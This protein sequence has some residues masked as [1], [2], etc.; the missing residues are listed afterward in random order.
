M[1]PS[2]ISR[3][4]ATRAISRRI[5]LWHEI[6][7]ASGV[8]SMMISTPVAASIARI[9]RPSRPMMRPFISSLGQRQHR[10][11]ALGDEL[12]RQP[13]DRDR[14]DPLGATVGLLARLLLDHPDMLGGLVPRLPDHLLDQRALGFLAGQPGDR[15]EPAA[16]FVNQRLMLG[17]L[18]G[19]RLL[20]I[21]HGL[22]APIEIGLAPLERLD[23]FLE[24]SP[25]APAAWSPRRSARAGARA[26]HVR[27]RR[28]R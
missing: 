26:A 24:A 23:P 8:S 7:T 13:L 22:V 17:F 20:A 1:R 16:R 3:S 12:A 15:L 5:G 21:T 19:D 14:D 4:S 27:S 28:A 6:T 18:V 2:E 10:D 25:R 11:R 9:L